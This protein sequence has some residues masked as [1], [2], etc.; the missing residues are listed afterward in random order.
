VTSMRSLPSCL[1]NRLLVQNLRMAGF[2]RIVAVFPAP[3]QSDKR[4]WAGNL[5]MSKKSR[6]VDTK[7]TKFQTRIHPELGNNLSQ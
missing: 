5:K 6:N 7:M 3:L 2:V 1:I 4:C